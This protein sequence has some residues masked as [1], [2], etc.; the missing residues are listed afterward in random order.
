MRTVAWNGSVEG[1]HI[2]RSS[3][4]ITIPIDQARTL[5]LRRGDIMSCQ[6]KQ[7]KGCGPHLI[8]R[9]LEIEEGDNA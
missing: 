2:R 3:F 9:K 7:P 4:S 1:G 5:G 6:L 8:L